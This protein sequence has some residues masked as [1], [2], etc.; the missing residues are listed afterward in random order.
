LTN[1]RKNFLWVGI[2]QLGRTTL[3][4]A[5]VAIMSRLLPPADF[6]L[7]AMALVVSNLAN[8]LKDMGLSAAVIQRDDLSPHFL[9]TVFW[10]T[11]GVGFSLAALILIVSPGI[12]YL[13]HQPRLIA[14]LAVLAINFPIGCSAATHQALMERQ[15]LFRRL[16]MIE[17]GAALVGLVGAIVMARA[18]FGV[19][20]LIGQT[21]LG[22]CISTLLIWYCSQ[23]RPARRFAREELRQIYGFSSNI[24]G[25]NIIN[26]FAR[27][28]DT[29]IIGNLLGAIELG[30]YNVAYRI[31][32]FPVQNLSMV[33]G[34]ALLPVYSRIQGDRE[35]LGR[36][37]LDTLGTIAAITA[38]LSVGV[39]VLRT[40]LILTVLGDNWLRSAEI[41][42]WFAPVS[43]FQSMVST[44]GTVLT[45]VGRTD[46]LRKLGVANTIITI[47]LF[48]IG[49]R[50][51]IVGVA[52]GYSVAAAIVFAQSL[53]WTLKVVDKSFWELLLSLAPQVGLA[54][55]MG[56][57]VSVLE[58]SLH[59]MGW[60][61]LPRTVLA[62]TAGA[63]VY[64]ALVLIFLP[65][66]TKRVI[67]RDIFSKFR[68]VSVKMP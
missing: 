9:D 51:G 68:R 39:W 47:V 30:F 1:L 33:A 61:P 53:T 13:F 16:A 31:M 37:Y 41:L 40:P 54:A 6:G 5:G 27:N 34:R 25:F 28:A 4:L 21:L 62:I 60:N 7:L 49:C 22:T 24:V 57:I 19:F 17:I 56:V 55:V 48:V 35:S 3:Q 26:Y 23:W 65:A 63:A 15:F 66:Q 64:G 8:L 10:F 58:Q 12:A 18:D 67:G 44:T 46:L 50:W 36:H 2:S 29:M 45:S 59:T 11:I 43:F 38:P 14:V 42:G 52:A 20:S 32:L